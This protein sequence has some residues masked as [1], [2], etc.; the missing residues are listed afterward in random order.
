MWEAHSPV[1]EAG[2]VEGAARVAEDLDDLLLQ[3]TQ[4]TEAVRYQSDGVGLVEARCC[5]AAAD[6]QQ[7]QGGGQDQRHA[8]HCCCSPTTVVC[9]RREDRWRF[10]LLNI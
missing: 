6:R 5:C 9:W 7:D 2:E 8:S 3:L 1:S 4:L 10:L